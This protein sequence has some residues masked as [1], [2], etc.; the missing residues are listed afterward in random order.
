[1]KK[2]LK[3]HLL[4]AI[5]EEIEKSYYNAKY[6]RNFTESTK[7]KSYLK[8]LDDKQIN[9]QGLKVILENISQNKKIYD[10]NEFIKNLLAGKYTQDQDLE[11]PVLD[12]E[13][14]SFF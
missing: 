5:Y 9:S 1:M 11:G 10:M 13:I 8:E 14:P 12:F 7:Y 3:Q 6:S 4:G 2:E